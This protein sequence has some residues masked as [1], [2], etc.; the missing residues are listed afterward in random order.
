[1]V[2]AGLDRPGN[3]RRIHAL[4][5]GGP[6]GAPLFRFSEASVVRH[7]DVE[8]VAMGGNLSMLC[9]L[10]GTG[11]APDLD[12]GILFLE[13]VGEPLYRLDRMLTHLVGSGTLRRVKALISGSLRGCR[14]ATERARRWP[15]LLAEAAPRGC[16][17]V[18]GLPFGHDAKNLAFPLGATVRVS[19]APG[20]VSWS[21]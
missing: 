8:G 1:M 10:Q 5:A 17:V 3:A 4:L 20:L 2:A 7:G 19:T 15:E 16:P 12:G 9:A 13:D 11:F 21:G 6:G 18:V 14:P